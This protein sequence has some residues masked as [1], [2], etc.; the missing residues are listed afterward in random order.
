MQDVPQ[1]RHHLDGAYV[2]LKPAYTVPLSSDGAF[3]D[4]QVS[5]TSAIKDVSLLTEQK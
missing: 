2:S 1:N 4:G 3:P 5:S